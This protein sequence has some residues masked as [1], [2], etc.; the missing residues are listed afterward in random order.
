MFVINFL[1][2]WSIFK[3]DWL[4]VFASVIL[5]GIFMLHLTIK[6]NKIEDKARRLG[7]LTPES[8]LWWKQQ[9]ERFYKSRISMEDKPSTP[10]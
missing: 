2:L 9:T 10:N 3:E 5:Y 4:S 6:K 7:V 1:F 8:A